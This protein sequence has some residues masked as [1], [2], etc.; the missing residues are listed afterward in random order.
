V[1]QS[2][3]QHMPTVQHRVKAP[4]HTMTLIVNRTYTSNDNTFRPNEANDLLI[5][6]AFLETNINNLEPIGMTCNNKCMTPLARV[7]L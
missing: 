3:T 7:N 2:N 5:N 1:F 6:L 4:S